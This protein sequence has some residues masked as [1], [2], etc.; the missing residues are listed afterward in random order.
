VDGYCPVFPLA[1]R[2][3]HDTNRQH[4]HALDGAALVTGAASGI[5]RT[6]AVRL[7]ARGHRVAVAGRSSGRVTGIAGGSAQSGGFIPAPPDRPP[8]GRVTAVEEIAAAYLAV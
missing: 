5:G 4:P 8:A 1:S 6:T 3:D 7:A 2:H